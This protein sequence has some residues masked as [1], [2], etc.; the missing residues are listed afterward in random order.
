MICYFNNG[1]SFTSVDNDYVPMAGEILFVEHATIDELNNAFPLYNSGN[2]ILSI[3]EQAASIEASYQ[4]KLDA[5]LR[6]IILA[7]A[8]DGETQGEK[9]LEHQTNYK[10]LADKMNAEIDGLY[11]GGA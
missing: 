5:Y 2:P 11:L 8:A 7:I 4:P 3:D 6:L 10:L 1:F 9:T